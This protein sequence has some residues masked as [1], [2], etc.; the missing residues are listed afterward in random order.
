MPKNIYCADC[1]MELLIFP[2]ALPRQGKVV[3]LVEPHTC[4]DTEP[5]F[6]TDEQGM[7]DK[8]KE[9]VVK[10]KEKPVNLD[11]VFNKFKFGHLK[12]NKFHC[13]IK[14]GNPTYF[15][16]KLQKDSISLCFNSMKLSSLL[17]K[18]G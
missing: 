4:E 11:A 9:L 7:A 13:H 1:G 10:E 14:K 2:K 18:V 12:N 3:T 8:E 16:Y 17:T 15:V 5:E 6:F